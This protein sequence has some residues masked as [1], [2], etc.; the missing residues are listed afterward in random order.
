MKYLSKIH[1][2]HLLKKQCFSKIKK[3]RKSLYFFS[4]LQ[5][6]SAFPLPFHCTYLQ[7][8]HIYYILYMLCRVTHNV[9]LWWLAYDIYLDNVQKCHWLCNN[10]YWLIVLFLNTLLCEPALLVKGKS[11][12]TL[13]TDFSFKQLKE[14]ALVFTP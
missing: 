4:K 1:F 5:P 13:Y 11:F 8:I 10:S 6:K 7:C 14:N 9:C 2:F 3:A 12:V